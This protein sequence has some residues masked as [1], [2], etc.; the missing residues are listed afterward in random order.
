MWLLPLFCLLAPSL[1]SSPVRLLVEPPLRV[2]LRPPAEPRDA[3]AVGTAW[4]TVP[5]DHFNPLD[6]RTYQMRYMYN[7]QFFNGTGAPIFIMVGGEWEISSGFLLTGNMFEMARENN[8]Y[9]IYTEHRFYGRTQPFATHST[10]NL[11]YLNVDQ[12]LADLATFIGMLKDQPRFSTS[13]VV[14]VGGSY[15]GNMVLWFKQRYAHLVLGTVASSA[16]IKAE[17]DFTGYLTVVESAFRAE[18]G[19]ACAAVL[20]DGIAATVAATETAEGRELLE[21]AF[22]ICPPPSDPL[23]YSD[24]FTMGYFSGFITW[25]LSGQVQNAR[26]AELRNL[27]TNLVNN[28]YGATPMESIGGLVTSG[29]SPGQC[30]EIRYEDYVNSYKNDAVSTGRAWYYQTCTEYAYFQIAPPT[31]SVFSPLSRWLNVE[32]YAD[33]CKQAYDS[34]FDESFVRASVARSNRM[35]GGLRPDVNNTIN[36]HGAIDPWHYLG[37]VDRELKESSPTYL[38]PRASHCFDLQ[39]WQVT[40][41]ARMTQVQQAARRTV[42]AWLHEYYHK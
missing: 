41:T 24:K 26:P 8:G 31:G 12:A 35:F 21:Q 37:V 5:V 38:V 18:G 3:R 15:A 4:V 10:E 36:I 29:L 14:L 1:G 23:D 11:R 13:P 22:K 20:R 34:R 33:L 7:E 27:C 40:D 39:P 25:T 42:A 30:Y 32:F 17:V 2:W 9:L 19:D 6:D 28:V 16:P